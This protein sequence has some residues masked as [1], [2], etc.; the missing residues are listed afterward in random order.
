MACKNCKNKE[1]IKKEMFESTAGTPK[2]ILWFTIIWSIF[3]I[4][5]IIEFIMDLI[6][7]IF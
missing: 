3:S 7:W 6:K 5:G 4:Y 1:K 2:G